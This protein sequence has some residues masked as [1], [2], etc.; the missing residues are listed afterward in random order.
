VVNAYQATFGGGTCGDE[1]CDDFFVT[2]LSADGSA[3]LYSTFLGGNEEDDGLGVAVDA[4]SYI[5]TVGVV[6]STGMPVM[7]PYQ[8][9]KSAGE[10][11]YLAVLDPAQSGGA[12]LLYASYFGGDDTDT[13][14]RVRVSSSG[15]A[16]VVGYTKSDDFPTLNPYQAGRAGNRDVFVAKVDPI[17]GGSAS[18]LYSTYL[19][20]SSVDRGLDLALAASDQVYVTGKTSSSNFPTANA[21]DSTYNGGTCGTRNCYDAFAFRLDLAT[22]TL[23][24][25]TYLGG[26]G[27]D[28]GNGITVDGSGNAYLT[29]YTKSSDFP[30]ASAIQSTK[31]GDGCSAP[32]CAD[33]FV[34]KL[35]TSGSALAYSTYLGGTGD[36]YGQAIVLDGLGG[37]YITGYTLS[38]DFPTVPGSYDT[39]IGSTYKDA[40]VVKIND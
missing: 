11:A 19:G 4:N 5:Y 28:E 25:S 13:A 33:A 32:P 37:A 36:D 22:N 15:H 40:F 31:G 21:Y 34:T 27:D 3:I 2:Q 10:D 17:A 12:S 23:A 14:Y 8:A 16:Y 18:L 9:A 1:P 26:S 38:G 30:V 6:E 39:V 7:N 35:E 24:Y 29:G 20:G